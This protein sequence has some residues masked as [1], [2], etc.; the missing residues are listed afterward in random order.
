[1]QIVA[2][3]KINLYLHVLG[4]RDDGY[5]LL[6]SLI[7]FAAARDILTVRQADALSLTIE[8]RFAGALPEADGDNLVLRAARALIQGAGRAR[9]AHI[10]LT[11]NLPVASG[12]GG[13]SSDAA[14]ALKLLNEFWRLGRSPAELVLLGAAL[15]AD[16]PVCL[17]GATSYIG[18]VGEAVDGVPALPEMGVVLVNP[19][20]AVST[21][22]V[23][24]ALAAEFSGPARLEFTPYDAASL[25]ISLAARRND[26]TAPAVALA[27][28]IDE[29]LSALE[30]RPGC[31]LSR[32]S[33]SGATCFGLFAES[34]AARR[35]ADGI[36]AAHEDWWVCET[37]FL[38]RAPLPVAVD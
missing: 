12:I 16:V 4:R 14:A 28:V 33:G 21:S 27:P 36:T 6:D 20:V 8:G 3:A 38:D 17:H 23:F 32:L 25:A 29:V 11:K 13:G 5:H 15:G 26:L 22:S 35:A 37:R 10:T 30:A 2:P 7:A 24:G 34:A 9:G 1:M 31:L 19:N 18:G